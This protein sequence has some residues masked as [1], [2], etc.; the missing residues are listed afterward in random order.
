MKWIEK[1][2]PKKNIVNDKS[3]NFDIMEDL[4]ID[5][6]PPAKTAIVE[7]NTNNEVISF[8]GRD[9][10]TKGY[11]DGYRSHSDELR[12]NTINSIKSDFRIKIDILIDKKRNT[13]LEIQNMQAET[14]KISESLNLQMV[15]ILKD[16]D[17][18]IAKLEK[19]KEYS[20]EDEGWVM[21]AI[22]QYNEG[23]VKG[24]SRYQ[25]EKLLGFSTGMFN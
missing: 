11:E 20:A 24:T 18:S 16:F 8:L 10:Y 21:K 12:K 2:L 3:E 1:L 25:E 22:H 13:S 9:F 17:R 5:N 23:F 4:F 15:N 19:E 7:E 6:N 14:G